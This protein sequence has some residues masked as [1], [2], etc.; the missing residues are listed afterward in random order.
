MKKSRF[1]DS[2]I[3]AVLKQADSDTQWWKPAKRQSSHA[4]APY[5]CS[6][7]NNG[8]AE[9]ATRWKAASSFAWTMTP[10]F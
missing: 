3:I 8:S 9:E 6:T 7:L 10:R 4:C 1:T 5:F 2:Q